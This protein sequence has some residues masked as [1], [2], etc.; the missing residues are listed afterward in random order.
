[1]A[2][3]Y[4]CV[5]F[6]RDLYAFIGADFTPDGAASLTRPFFSVSRFGEKRDFLLS[7]RSAIRCRTLLG[8]APT[9]LFSTLVVFSSSVTSFTVNQ[10]EGRR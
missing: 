9:R 3:R 5:F 2:L 10:R 6:W 1:M 7:L 4:R 8:F